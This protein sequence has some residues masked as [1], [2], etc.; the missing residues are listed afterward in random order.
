M[1]PLLDHYNE[2]LRYLRE[3]GAVFARENPQVA[4]RLGIHPDAVT[5][6]FVERLLEG[7]AFLSA[8]VHAR[9]DRECAEFAHQA[10]AHLAPG[11]CRS[12]P[13]IT[14]FAFHPDFTSPE[15]QRGRCIPK[16]SVVQAVM[17]GAPGPI[18]FST[19]RPVCML[20]LRISA[21]ECARSAQG[22]PNT[23]ALRLQQTQA[24]VRL[25]FEVAGNATLSDIK[26]SLDRKDEEAPPLTLTFG[27]DGPL[28][29]GLHEALLA[30]A[31]HV[32]L[33]AN[34]GRAHQV[35]ELAA[36]A[37]RMALGDRILPEGD[38]GLHGVHVMREY[39]AQPSAFL[40][41]ELH[42]LEQLANRCPLARTFELIVGLRKTPQ[43]LLGRVTAAMIHLF[44]TPVV[45]L[46]SR[47][48]DPLI[49]D[50]DASAHW[51]VVDR[52]KPAAHDLFALQ[53]VDAIS[54]NGKRLRLAPAI[55][56]ARADMPPPPGH[57]CLVRK[58]FNVTGKTAE[59]P[60]GRRDRLV[61]SAPTLRMGDERISSIQMTG[62][63]ADRGWNRDELLSA[64]L[65]LA[66]P[67]GTSRIECLWVPGLARPMPDLAHCW[68]AVA[69][70]GESPLAAALRRSHE[71]LDEL[72]R[73]VNL[74][75]DD[76]SPVDERRVA[77]LKSFNVRSVLTPC[78]SSAPVGWIQGM[79]AR[80]DIDS[81]H[82]SDRGGW[83]FGRVLAQAISHCVSVNEGIEVELCIDGTIVS[84][85]SNLQLEDGSFV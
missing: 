11:F 85:H 74:A 37:L 71:P 65:S 19:T 17:P 24:V 45:N 39:L 51:V 59:G 13:S 18:K 7:L 14:T 20:P 66:E 29:H 35:V 61:V 78:A 77:S 76:T 12:T 81:A 34:D 6:P 72:K 50:P 32:L 79:S 58:D 33:L 42:G 49:Y 38:G 55:G 4:A 2:E 63:V 57:F 23:A 47:R 43:Q 36:G 53:Q 80:I 64:N 73:W 16:G 5:D 8:R 46:Y 10:L 62:L 68:Q 15:S 28:C 56:S 26:R 41:V 75:S 52:V 67:M 27:G 30:D 69:Y 44:A 40:S 70:L 21:A 83:L 48:L 3:E 54:V 9:M 60:V 22:L 84:R 31:E 82:H 1:T 25:R